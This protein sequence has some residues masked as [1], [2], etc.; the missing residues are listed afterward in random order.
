MQP[1]EFN[2]LKK[3]LDEFQA[4][5]GEQISDL[6]TRMEHLISKYVRIGGVVTD[7]DKIN[8]LKKSLKDAMWDDGLTQGWLQAAPQVV[9]L[10]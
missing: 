3:E 6:D 2:R 7:K 9:N 1:G 4:K 5:K 10:K 8:Y